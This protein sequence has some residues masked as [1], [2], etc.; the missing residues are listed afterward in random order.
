MAEKKEMEPVVDGFEK[1]E[2]TMNGAESFVE[3]HQKQLLIGFAAIVAVVVCYFV[4]DQYVWQPKEEE[5]KAEIRMAQQMFGIDSFE[6]ALNG[7]EDE[8]SGFLDII[9]NYGSTKSGNL[10]KAYAGLCYKQL[11][12]NEQA[13]KYL[14]KFSGKDGL[15]TP[16]IEGAVAD[17]YWDLEEPAKAAKTYVSAAKNADNDMLS[18]LYL[19]RAAMCQMQL[20]KNA[21]AIKLLE[22]VVSD[23]PYCADMPEVMKYLEV[24]KAAK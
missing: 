10:A 5:A 13:I 24:A 4:L 15:V 7:K 14:N 12:D 16:A 20:G 21:E 11:G 19:K 8:F 22:Q 3:S 18:P 9:D 17:C 2:S 23:Y 1:I 6:V